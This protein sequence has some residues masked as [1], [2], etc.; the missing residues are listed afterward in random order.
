MCLL[1]VEI[2]FFACFLLNIL[3]QIFGGLCGCRMFWEGLS[4]PTDKLRLWLW[5]KHFSVP[6]VPHLHSWHVAGMNYFTTQP[7][8]LGHSAL[9]LWKGSSFPFSSQSMALLKHFGSSDSG[10][11]QVAQ[12]NQNTH[13]IAQYKDGG[14]RS[15]G[16]LPQSWDLN[17]A[18]EDQK[19]LY[20]SR[21][22]MINMQG[23]QDQGDTKGWEHY[24]HSFTS[25]NPFSQA[26]LP[27]IRI[28]NGRTYIVGKAT[29]LVWR[30]QHR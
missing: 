1:C 28:V 14:A 13:A 16:W 25:P 24:S 3:L 27:H 30:A 12:G 6:W 9:M 7:G 20:N 18:Y 2:F 29:S 21:T 23:G 17:A 5:G 4:I 8:L 19:N 11:Q 15:V 22:S 10:D 26:G